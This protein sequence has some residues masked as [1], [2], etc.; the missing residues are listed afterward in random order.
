MYYAAGI[1]FN[2]EALRYGSQIIDPMLLRENLMESLFYLHGQ[3]PLFNLFLGLVLKSAGDYANFSFWAILTIL[4]LVLHVAMYRLL[5]DFGFSRLASLCVVTVYM[6]GPTAISYESWLFYT[7]PIAT[8]LTISVLALRKYLTQETVLWSGVFFG[9]LCVVALTRSAFH[10]VWVLAVLAGLILARPGLWRRTVLGVSLPLA[11]VI[12]VYGKNYALFSTF[13]ASS[14]LG[15][16]LATITI[17]RLPESDRLRLIEAGQLSPVSRLHPYEL[18]H[19]FVE[20]VPPPE[21]RHIQ[22]LDTYYK[23]NG[24]RNYNNLIFVDVFKSYLRDSIRIMTLRPIFYLRQVA[25][26][27]LRYTSPPT[28]STYV[29]FNAER[30]VPVVSIYD[31]ALYGRFLHH[32]LS[33]AGIDKDSETYELARQAGVFVACALVL[34]FV[35]FVASF[36]NLVRRRPIG[37]DEILRL[38]MGFTIIYISMLAFFLM[39]EENNRIRTMIEPIMV[40]SVISVLKDGAAGTWRRLRALVG[41]QNG[42]SPN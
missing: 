23:T 21:P 35:T 6:L 3:P 40:V 39:S 28:D 15:F 10:L 25:R 7:W 5:C 34:I 33:W 11:L 1:R 8:L 37:D 4:S 36:A 38:Y 12:L 31:I 41:L 14:W 16:H 13:S 32:A 42:P 26:A 27:M 30:I 20:V 22:I 18:P 17:A 9:L 29:I 19:R 24:E 2:A